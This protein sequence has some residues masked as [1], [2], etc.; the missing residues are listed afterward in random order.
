MPHA[1]TPLVR[2]FATQGS[3]KERDC[4]SEESNKRLPGCVPRLLVSVGS[5]TFG[6]VEKITGQREASSDQATRT[7]A[8]TKTD[9]YS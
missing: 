4:T 2:L 1:T 7:P 6:L 9:K 8:R 5:T 3:G